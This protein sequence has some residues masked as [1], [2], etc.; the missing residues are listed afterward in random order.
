MLS[1]SVENLVAVMDA[2]GIDRALL[3]G[4]CESSW[5]GLLAAARHPDRVTG[6]VAIAPGAPDGTPGHDRG[7]DLAAN[8]AADLTEPRGWQLRNQG[9]WR[10]EWPSY[11]RWF[12]SQICNDP[13]SSKLYEDV[14]EWADQTSGGV[15]LSAYDAEAKAF[16]ADWHEQ[17]APSDLHALVRRFFKPG[18]T[19]D[20]GAG[21]GR[22][23][24]WLAANG[25]AVRFAL[26]RVT[27]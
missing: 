6:V 23:V 8:W 24:A 3:V 7:I 2:C 18:R 22:E 20:I 21:S 9:V 17:P 14:V 27:P 13:H 5:F 19:A 15:M 16:A 12:F 25:F 11:P 26:A 10:R 1:P 4:L